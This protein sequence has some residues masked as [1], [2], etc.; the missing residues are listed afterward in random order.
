M[1]R[2]LLLG[3]DSNSRHR[4]LRE[5]QIPFEVIGH[6]A[7]ETSCCN[8]PGQSF[9][10][11]VEQIALS[12]MEHV[13]LEARS[14]RDKTCF[15]LTADTLCQT[16]DGQIL[17]KPADRAAAIAMI[18]AAR[19]GASVVTAFCLDKRVCAGD[20]WQ[21]ENRIQKVVRSDY[22]FCVPDAWL[23]KYLSVCPG[24]QTAGAVAIEKFGEQFLQVVHGSYSTIV[25]LP[26][27]ELREALEKIG[28]YDWFAGAE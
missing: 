23:E 5:A 4:L 20:C 1:K 22:I 11:L 18:K 12:K 9:E 27:F 21:V 28:F 26:I 8:T 15:I 17:G 6:L 19:A 7:D 16:K 14:K 13:N 24:L 10:A 2:V 25:G 3:S